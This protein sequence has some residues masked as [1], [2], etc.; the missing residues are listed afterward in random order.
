M[1]LHIIYS[2][3]SVGHDYNQT[4]MFHYFCKAGFVSRTSHARQRVIH[5]LIG[6][7][8]GFWNMTTVLSTALNVDMMTVLLIPHITLT[9]TFCR[10]T[11]IISSSHTTFKSAVVL[12]KDM[13]YALWETEILNCLYIKHKKKTKEVKGKEKINRILTLN[14]MKKRPFPFSLEKGKGWENSTQNV[15][16]PYQ[17]HKRSLVNLGETLVA[18]AL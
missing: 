10:W 3:Y 18:S 11:P 14:T 8:C 2:V 4:I 6:N 17:V 7:W 13:F 15:P 12:N 16:L 9:G 5:C 1:S